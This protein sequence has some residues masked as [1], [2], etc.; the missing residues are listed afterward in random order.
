MA[1]STQRALRKAILELPLGQLAAFAQK[2]INGQPLH[3]ALGFSQDK[4]FKQWLLKH[5]DEIVDS[6]EED[7][8]AISDESADQDEAEDDSNP[9]DSGESEE[10]T[11]N[12]Y[13]S[14]KPMAKRN[15]SQP[16]ERSSKIRVSRT[17]Q[18]VFVP[19]SE[20]RDPRFTQQAVNHSLIRNR[21]EFLEPMRD[22][23]IVSLR[24][25]IRKQEALIE[26]PK[27][28]KRNLKRMSEEELADAKADLTRLEQY[29]GDIKRAKDYQTKLH[30]A[31]QTSKVVSATTKKK[32][33]LR[34][35]Y[36][37]LAQNEHRF[38]RF[39]DKKRKE[40][41]YKDRKRNREQGNPSGG[42]GPHLGV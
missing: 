29:R 21:Y 22:T 30:T 13:Q 1:E 7:E 14:D 9:S 40:G 12:P 4:E 17:R 10:E 24:G 19:R 39:V 5:K 38:K 41:E 32:L 34:V 16:S 28:R 33:K 8:E 42:S 27:K 31:K 35:R 25:Q 37:D 18:V 15:R 23:E 11:A 3:R 20:S 2:G 36:E 26:D 6:E